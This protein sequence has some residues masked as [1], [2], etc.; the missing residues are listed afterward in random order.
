M[1]RDFALN[2]FKDIT[3]K[4][5]CIAIVMAEAFRTVP[6]RGIPEVEPIDVRVWKVIVGVHDTRTKLAKVQLELNLKIGELQLKAQLSM[7]PE[8]RD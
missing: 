8:I 3:Y 5:Q 6:E 4:N 2:L 1:Q 7:L